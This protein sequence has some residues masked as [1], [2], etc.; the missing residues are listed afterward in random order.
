M[1]NASVRHWSRPRVP[2]SV[3]SN[4]RMPTWAGAT[5]RSF[6][7]GSGHPAS[8]NF[9]DLFSYALAK[10]RFRGRGTRE[11]RRRPNLRGAI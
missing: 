8:L 3:I 10:L 4:D 9:G 7:K 1:A 6:G 2:I 11:D 5:I